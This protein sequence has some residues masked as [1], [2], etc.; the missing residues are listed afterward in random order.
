MPLDNLDNIISSLASFD[1]EQELVQIIETNGAELVRMQKEQLA[2]DV[3]VHGEKRFDMYS[4]PYARLKVR[5]YIGLG[6]QVDRVTFYAK[7]GLY[8]MLQL[9][10]EGNEFYVGVDFIGFEG[11]VD[12]IGDSNYGIDETN[13]LK[14]AE[15]YVSP[16]IQ[17]SF[18]I[19]VLGL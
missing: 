13:R 7:G 12:R 19:K 5:K 9:I 11:M 8:D 18:A 1:A 15:D 2:A 3:D 4:R 17:A 6:A 14:F 16:G 10:L